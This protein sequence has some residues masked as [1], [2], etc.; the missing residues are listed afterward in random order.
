MQVRVIVVVLYLSRQSG[1]KGHACNLFVVRVGSHGVPSSIRVG[2][3]QHDD[4]NK[5]LSLETS[6]NSDLYY[7][8]HRYSRELC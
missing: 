3:S 7:F 2:K 1:V 8:M 6:L 4:I 5:I